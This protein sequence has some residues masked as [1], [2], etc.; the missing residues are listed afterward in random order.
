MIPKLEELI[1]D[2]ELKRVHG[3]ANFGPDTTPRQVV[4]SGVPQ[5][6]FGFSTGHTMMTI[7]IEHKLLRRP[8][9]GKYS[10]TLTKFGMSYL[11][12]MT[13]LKFSEIK[14]LVNADG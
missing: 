1:S 8:R 11:R 9:P 5:Y 13:A 7:L 4:N 3:K 6:A 12:A 10:S 14:A 2:E